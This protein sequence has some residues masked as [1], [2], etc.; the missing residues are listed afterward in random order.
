[1]G[2]YGNFGEL[3]MCIF[4]AIIKSLFLRFNFDGS[5]DQNYIELLIVV[6]SISY[7]LRLWKLKKQ[8]ELLQLENQGIA[9]DLV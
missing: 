9:R 5:F 1:M 4:V 7:F 6:D 8:L 2:K 3:F